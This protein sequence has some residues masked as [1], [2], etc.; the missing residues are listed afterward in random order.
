MG[1][2]RDEAER[3]ARS[4][5]LTFA[6]DELDH[7]IGQL[8]EIIA[9]TARVQEVATD[10]IRPTYD[11][12]PPIEDL[13]DAAICTSTSEDADLQALVLRQAPMPEGPRR[14]RPWPASLSV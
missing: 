13:G 3:L 8:D 2:T 9:A 12:I 7:L 11:M 4:S 6:D 10:G 5:K 1:L 14:G